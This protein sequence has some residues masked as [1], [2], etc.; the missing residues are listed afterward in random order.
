LLIVINNSPPRQCL[1]ITDT[2]PTSFFYAD[3]F[4]KIG[5]KKYKLTDEI[6]DAWDFRNCHQ[7]ENGWGTVLFVPGFQGIYAY[8]S[9][10]PAVCDFSAQG[11]LSF[12]FLK[13]GHR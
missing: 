11:V 4:F 8:G 5:D 3:A 2:S 13:L 9:V 7:F 12:T 1:Y 10:P 6:P